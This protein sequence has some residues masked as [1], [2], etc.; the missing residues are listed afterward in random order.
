MIY[1]QGN[2][3][4]RII[5]AVVLIIGIPLA[6]GWWFLSGSENPP[7]PTTSNDGSQSTTA[8]SRITQTPGPAGAGRVATAVPWSHRWVPA[9]TDLMEETFGNMVEVSSGD[10]RIATDYQHGGYGIYC[11]AAHVL[12]PDADETL[13]LAERIVGTIPGTSLCVTQAGLV[14]WYGGVLQSD[15]QAIQVVTSTQVITDTDAHTII[16]TQFVEEIVLNARFGV[17]GPSVQP[18]NKVFKYSKAPN[19]AMQV[20][21][22]ASKSLWPWNRDKAFFEKKIEEAADL[23]EQLMLY[24]SIAPLQPGGTRN[25]APLE[26]LYTL[27]T[28]RFAAPSPEP[29]NKWP[30]D[31]LLE[32]AHLA[33]QA[34]GY[35]GFSGKLT[36]YINKPYAG[37]YFLQTVGTDH[38]VQVIPPDLDKRFQ[39][40]LFSLFYGEVDTSWIQ[41]WFSNK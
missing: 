19:K 23:S 20:F 37:Y 29:E 9:D 33:V 39:D 28:I 2:N 25:M 21:L 27:T 11:T 41:Q 31:N 35:S 15:L 26:E 32:Y 36:V 7:P 3:W 34:G 30:Y 24:D 4:F 14:D 13:P 40:N 18:G 10:W 38:P 6:L 1:R 17:I 22:D 16:H 5:L 12:K 8:I